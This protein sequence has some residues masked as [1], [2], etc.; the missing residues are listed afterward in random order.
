VTKRAKD[1]RCSHWHRFWTSVYSVYILNPPEGLESSMTWISEG[2]PLQTFDDA[3][4]QLL[5]FDQGNLFTEKSIVRTFFRHS[6]G[7]KRV[8]AALSERC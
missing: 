3:Y 1:G 2:P 7:D 8:Q 6:T 5:H 4:D